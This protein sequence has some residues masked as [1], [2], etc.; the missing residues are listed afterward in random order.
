MREAPQFI[1]RL[2]DVG[3]ELGQDLPDPVIVA[4]GQLA[5]Q[6]QLDRERGEPLLGA[7]VEVALDP[8]PL[9]IGGSHDPRPRSLEFGR[10][11]AQLLYRG[12]QRGAELGVVRGEFRP[13]GLEETSLREVRS[14]VTPDRVPGDPDGQAGPGGVSDER[15]EQ[16]R[17]NRAEAREGQCMPGVVRGKARLDVVGE[18]QAGR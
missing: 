14:Q 6:T 1:R 9:A 3:A 5:S 12:R 18:P 8:A 10:L 13:L 15:A 7:I 11:T 17:E 16:C 4:F 2:P